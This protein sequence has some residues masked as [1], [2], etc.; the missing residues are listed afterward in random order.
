[1]IIETEFSFDM[2]TG[3]YRAWITER[4]DGARARVAAHV[5]CDVVSVGVTTGAQREAFI[6][7]ADWPR[8]VPCFQ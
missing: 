2:V 3:S 8:E 1:M 4:S 5:G 6:R 7:A